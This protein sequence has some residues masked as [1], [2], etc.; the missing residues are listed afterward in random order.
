MGYPGTRAALSTIVLLLAGIAASSAFAADQPPL[1]LARTGYLYAGGKID[2]AA[3]NKPYVGHLYA[4]YMIPARQR[5]P[6]PI[7]MV[8]GGSQT[9]TN[10]TGT[11][12]G[13]EGWAQYFARRG[14][15]V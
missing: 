5:H 4:E 10:F 11:I 15:A 1:N 13:K 6:Y 2:D 12:E 8:P 7:V 3:P 14:Y 9:G